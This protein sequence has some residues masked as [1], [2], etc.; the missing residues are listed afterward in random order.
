MTSPTIS[1]ED[2][3]YAYPPLL[4][5]HAAEDVLRGVTC[6]V[7][8]GELVGL[9]GRVGSGKSTLCMTINGLAPH[10]TGGR[11]RGR[12]LV[13]GHDTRRA[14]VAALA[15]WAG[16][17]FQD[18]EA[19]LTQMQ[20]EDEIAFG[21]ENLG[22]PPTIIAERVA[23]A[24]DAVGLTA[25]RDRSP[26]LLSGGEK[27]RVAIAAL[28]AM[29]PEALVLDDPTANLDPAGKSA[30]FAALIALARRKNLA[31]LVATQ[32]LDLLARYADR[33]LVLHEGRI[34]LAGR[35]AAV[36]RQAPR[37]LEWGIG[38]PQLAALAALLSHR[39]GRAYI[40]LRAELPVNTGHAQTPPA[41]AP[42]P[43]DAHPP[44]SQP[45]ISLQNTSYIYPDGT[46]ALR[47]VNLTLAPGE[48]V[49][50]L[51]PN[52]SGKT[53]LGK[54]L[55]GLLRPTQGQV[56][57]E[58]RDTRAA[59]VPELGR[60]IGY[61][62]QNPDH[63]IFAPTVAAE[64]AFA[65]R[66]QGLPPVEVARRVAEAL[67]R[68]RLAGQAHLPP[69]LLGSSQRRQVALAAILAARP[70]VLV[71]DEP[72]GGLDSRS[73]QELMAA[74]VSFNRQG[75]TVLLITHDM[76]LVAEYAARAVV[77]LDGQVL[78]DGAPRALFA[79]PDVMAQAHL[80]PPAVIRLAQRLAPY[81]FADSLTNAEFVA[82]WQARSRAA[83]RGV[84]ASSEAPHAR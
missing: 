27:Q 75:G 58:G 10:A 19:Q 30:I 8:R 28:L 33:V 77:M 1:I 46:A 18:P 2:L 73:Q 20:V 21:P 62:F 47:Q 69:A 80:A 72:T 61:V 34:A 14:P 22:L 17:V 4:A 39:T 53:T 13:A 37:L 64:V 81:G 6:G 52:G 26:L 12:V 35:P 78:F 68:F 63:Q 41:R 74:V 55:N 29:Q 44:A 42:K 60:T 31:V 84:T 59:R 83:M 43:T 32:D 3:H 24:L 54:L 49:T 71:L 9:I 36:F 38:A 67:D 5:G 23:W 79:R 40:H 70:R 15:R 45:Q 48:F 82:T 25:Y 50:L 11:F 65:L 76:R 16:L 57:V 56:I 7:Q 51:G 66:L